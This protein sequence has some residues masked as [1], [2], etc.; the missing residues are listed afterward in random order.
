VVG[1][2]CATA[3]MSHIFFMFYAFLKLCLGYS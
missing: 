2:I 3:V 1:G